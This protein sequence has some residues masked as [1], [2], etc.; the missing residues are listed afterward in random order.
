MIG[1][2]QKKYD[3]S[4]A[5]RREKIEQISAK[6]QACPEINFAYIYGSFADGLSF[7]DIDIGLFLSPMKREDS[8][9]YMLDLSQALNSEICLPVDVRVINDVPV[10]FL[11]SVIQGLLVLVRDEEMHTRFVE[12]VIK[13][14]LDLKPRIRRAIKEAF[15]S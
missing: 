9:F 6:L 13:E 1:Y 8:I 10:T 7:H 11:Y 3:L 2:R 4:G 5:Q 15:T 14:Y 12:E